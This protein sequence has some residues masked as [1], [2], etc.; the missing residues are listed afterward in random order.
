[1]DSEDSQDVGDAHSSSSSS[2]SSSRSR[3]S[4]SPAS[5][6]SK[7][8]PKSPPLS[9][10]SPRPRGPRSPSPESRSQS[11]P[12]PISKPPRTPDHLSDAHSD[13][14]S[15]ETSMPATSNEPKSPDGPKS[16]SD[17]GN[18]SPE[19]SE[20]FASAPPFAREGPKT[21]MSCVLCPASPKS[22][23]G[24]PELR[25]RPGSPKSRSRPGSPKS[26]SRPAS[27]D[28]RSKP[29]SP[30]SEPPSNKVGHQ[31]RSVS[32]SPGRNSSPSPGRSPSDKRGDWSPK[33][34]WRR[35]TKG[36]QKMVDVPLRGR[37][38]SRSESSQSSRSSSYNKR[39]NKDTAA[40]DISEGEMESDQEDSKPRSSRTKAASKQDAKEL[41]ISHEDLSD[42]SDL[43]SVGQ[44]DTEKESKP[45]SPPTSPVNKQ[46]TNVN[47]V[48]Q[49]LSPKSDNGKAD[50]PKLGKLP[51]EKTSNTEDGEEQ[52]DFEAEEGECV[53]PKPVEQSNGDGD[54][55]PEQ[56]EVKPG[57][58]SRG[59]S[60][61]EGEVSD[62]AERRPEESE[63]RPVCR[64]FSR[65]ACTFLH[66]GVTDKGNYNMFDVVRGV[67]SS[68]AYPA[69]PPRDVAP[70]E[71]AW[72]RGL[73]TAKEVSIFDL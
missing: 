28:S 10:Q 24:S 46:P 29:G 25:S 65:G 21:P 7:K 56:E 54:D 57:R 19:Q 51:Q 1:M 60:L 35:H 31:S 69:A 63:P 13:I 40:Q 22:P 58:R 52:L 67:P 26:R 71:S 6:R 18:L 8:G 59:S 34:K 43:D 27:P 33:D 5:E 72:E 73:R 45:K 16:P 9:P 44:E 17:E 11:P 20:E 64:F 3:R 49:D 32:R 68:G 61:E 2:S 12:A 39:G 14:N 55:K 41:N 70:P 50:T 30:D 42:V 23:S 48:G 38:R 36:A 4:S 15:P 62:E 47:G 53:E 66:P 37:E